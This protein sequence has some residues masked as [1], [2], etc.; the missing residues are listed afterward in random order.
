MSEALG[1]GIGILGPCLSK[2]HSSP[3][4]ILLRLLHID[5]DADVSRTI[6]LSPSSTGIPGIAMIYDPTP[7]L[8]TT[9]SKQ[10]F[11]HTCGML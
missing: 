4:H 6:V 2:S 9:S 7:G 3:T 5:G 8:D 1:F 10:K 11:L